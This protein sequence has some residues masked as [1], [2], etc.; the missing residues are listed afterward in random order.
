[1]RHHKAR[2]LNLSVELSANVDDETFAMDQSAPSSPGVSYNDLLSEDSVERPYAPCPLSDTEWDLEEAL[3]RWYPEEAL[4][5][6]DY[7]SI[8]M[9]QSA[10]SSPGVSY[11][12]LLSRSETTGPSHVTSSMWS[13]SEGWWNPDDPLSD[14]VWDLEEALCV[15]DSAITVPQDER[16][17]ECCRAVLPAPRP[18]SCKDCSD[19]FQTAQDRDNHWNAK[20][21]PP[22]HP[23]RTKYKCRVCAKGF[24]T[25]SRCIAHRLNNC[26]P[27]D[28]PDRIKLLV[29]TRKSKN[30]RYAASELVRV[31]QAFGDALRRLLKN[32]G[33]GKIACPEAILG[34]TYEQLIA[35]LNDN[36]RGLIYGDPNVVLHIDHIRP[37]ASFNVVGCYVEM[38]KC[39]NF[40]NLQLLPGLENRRKRCSF[41]PAEE[42][43]YAI[44][45][46]G[47]AIVELEKG[48]RAAGDMCT[49][50]LCTRDRRHQ[51]T[52]VE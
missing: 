51:D 31:K 16:A 11:N 34:C 26:V 39:A 18:F 37:I 45:K 10:P 14:T 2:R 35:H 32:M 38:Y 40:N 19:T 4:C 21:S 17:S 27:K 24:P 20:C 36:D 15:A 47:M 46:G 3:F 7:E 25:S 9:D 42:A 12:D 33:L 8:T 6:A 48:W 28:D 22:D 13:A 1:M 29:L 44:S 5:V 41:T 30:A 43:A 49:C 52:L 50:N 23:S